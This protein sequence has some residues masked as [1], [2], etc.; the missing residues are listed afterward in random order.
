MSDLMA[1]LGT[2]KSQ[3]NEYLTELVEASKTQAKAGSGRRSEIIDKK[4][5]PESLHIP[6]VDD[7]KETSGSSNDNS[8]RPSVVVVPEKK[9]KV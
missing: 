7:P 1:A 6:G 4:Q 3:T 8:T 2:I 5:C 9:A